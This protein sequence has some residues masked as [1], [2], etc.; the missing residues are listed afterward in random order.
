MLPNGQVIDLKTGTIVGLS[1]TAK[2]LSDLAGC[3][4]DEAAYAAACAAGDPLVYQVTSAPEDPAAGGLGYGLGCLFPGRVGAE[5]FLTRGHLHQR[6]EAAEVYIGL[7]GHGLMVLEDERTGR[8]TTLPLHAGASVYVPGYLAHRTVNTGDE[9][10]IYW[11][12]YPNDAG[13]DYG[14]V[15]KRNFSQI[16]VAVDGAPTVV[17]RP[18]TDAGRS[19]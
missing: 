6:R 17:K 2:R 16:V 12:V 13:H 9:P 8:C 10:L 1:P 5:Y 19:A 14:F 11:G 7:R 4:A 15:A 3:W 18:K